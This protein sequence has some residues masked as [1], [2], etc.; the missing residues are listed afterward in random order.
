MD[1]A[2]SLTD[3][4]FSRIW[5]MT[6]ALYAKGK[7]LEESLRE[8]TRTYTLELPELMRQPGGLRVARQGEAEM[9]LTP[10][11]GDARSYTLVIT[12]PGSAEEPARTSVTPLST[13]AAAPTAT[14]TPDVEADDPSAAPLKPAPHGFHLTL[15]QGERE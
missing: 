1:R 6:S 12:T 11:K 15:I 5:A 4:E 10:R 3:E 9:R 13:P 7:S 14:P 8:A 2:F